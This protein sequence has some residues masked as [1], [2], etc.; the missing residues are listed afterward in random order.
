MAKATG[1]TIIGALLAL[2]LALGEHHTLGKAVGWTLVALC[3]ATSISI[4]V[5]ELYTRRET[6][7]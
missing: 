6:H 7:R 3:A 4:V 5:V 2:F 1:Y